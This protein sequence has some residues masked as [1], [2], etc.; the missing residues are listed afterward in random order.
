MAKNMAVKSIPHIVGGETQGDLSHWKS[1]GSGKGLERQME[2][3]LLRGKQTESFLAPD[4]RVGTGL[5]N[6]AKKGF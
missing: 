1:V 4:D 6:S 5:T 2:F 3:R